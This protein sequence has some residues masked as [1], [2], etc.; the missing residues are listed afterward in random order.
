MLD[1]ALELFVE[2]SCV[3]RGLYLSKVKG[4]PW[5][6][7]ANPGQ[8]VTKYGVRHTCVLLNCSEMTE[9]NAKLRLS[10]FGQR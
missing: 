7:L 2:Y 5:S 3:F 9:S 1:I 8:T 10:Q 6:S 4:L